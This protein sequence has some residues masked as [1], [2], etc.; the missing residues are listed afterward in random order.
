L[1]K[2]FITNY[3]KTIRDFSPNARLYLQANFLI[4]LSYAVAGVIF[5][6]YLKEAGFKEGFIGGMLS[7]SGLAFGLF[8]IPAALYS[9]KAGRKRSMLGASLLGSLFLLARALTVSRGLLVASSFLGGLAM[10]VYTIST[11]PFMMENSRPG[12][13]THLFSLSFAVMLLAGVLGNLIGGELPEMLN[14][15]AKGLGKLWCYRITLVAG[16]A[17]AFASLYPLSRMTENPAFDKNESGPVWGG[18]KKDWELIG[19]FSWCNLWV[20]LGAGLVI[21]FFNLYFAQRFKSTSGQIGIYFSVAQ[22]ATALAVMAGPQLAKKMGKVKTVVLMELLSLPFLVTLGAVDNILTLAVLAFWM[23]ASLM[24]M[25][26]PISNA[27]TMEVLS[28]KMRA[29]ANSVTAMAWNLSWALSTA[30]SG[31]MM[32]RYGYSV[33]YYL[34]AFCYAVSAVSYYLF[35]VKVEKNMVRTSGQSPTLV[36]GGLSNG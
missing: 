4:G 21:P 24:Q 11:A 5:N 28:Q 29:T 19:K 30:L 12:E 17:M 14:L 13:R 26:S 10:T 16:S 18:N 23:R 15:L 22:V 8:A 6:L 1:I 2:R 20:G 7:L 25:S 9:D 33:P 32:Q 31:W 3:I 35:F 27:F 36:L 34:T